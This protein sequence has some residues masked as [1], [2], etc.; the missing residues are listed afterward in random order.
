MPVRDT[1]A[2]VGTPAWVDL[3]SSDLDRSRDFYTQLFGWTYDQTGPEFGSYINFSSAGHVV[4]GAMANM[5][6]DG[7]ASD[8][9]D[10]WTVYLATQDAEATARAVTEHGGQVVLAPMQVGDVGTMALF[11]DPAG[12]VFGVWQAGTHRG[13]ELTGEPF[14]PGWHELYSRDFAASKDFYGKVFGTGLETVGDTDDFRYSAITSGQTQYA[15]IMDADSFLPEGVPSHWGVYFS[16]EDVSATVAKAT[17][18]GA[19]VIQTPEDTPFGR[20]ATVIDP[21]GAQVKF[22]TP[23]A[24][25]AAQG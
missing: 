16:V 13:S 6:P 22:H 23:P 15:G 9:P 12:A 5:N 24:G 8:R 20:L 4:A 11:A 3:A 25:G 7:Q 14:G 19:T 10:A 1:P 2:P 17:E 21:T 18:L